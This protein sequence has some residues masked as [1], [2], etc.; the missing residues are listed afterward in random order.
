MESLS[1]FTVSHLNAITRVSN[2]SRAQLIKSAKAVGIK[3][4][5]KSVDIK[6][7]I[8]LIIN[9]TWNA[10]VKVC[11]AARVVEMP[12]MTT[13]EAEE[14]LCA[15]C[16]KPAGEQVQQTRQSQQIGSTEFMN[17][18]ENIYFS[19]KLEKE[20]VQVVAN[21]RNK[22]LLKIQSNDIPVGY[23][24]CDRDGIIR[25][26]KLGYKV[27]AK[28]DF[29]TK[30]ERQYFGMVDMPAIF[31]NVR[32]RQCVVAAHD[33]PQIPGWSCNGFYSTEAIAKTVAMLQLV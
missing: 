24:L 17:I 20:N 19:G 25:W 3:A 28:E 32:S 27:Q 2:Y 8:M 30:F 4:V 18:V 1:N 11:C 14:A 7:K 33:M 26:G 6:A 15:V 9:Q 12:A 29:L 10:I 31:M 21:H 23:C 13:A 22:Q 5:G 16:E